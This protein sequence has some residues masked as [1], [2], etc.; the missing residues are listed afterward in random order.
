MYPPFLFYIL[1]LLYMCFKVNFVYCIMYQYVYYSFSHNSLC[2]I[3]LDLS[4]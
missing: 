2:L 4:L 1:S 3:L